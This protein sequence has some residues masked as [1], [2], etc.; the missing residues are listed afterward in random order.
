MKQP[1]RLFDF[2]YYQLQNQPLEKMMSSRLAGEWH[3]ISTQDFVEK[4]NLVSRGL[5]AMGIQ[6]GDAISLI[7]ENNRLE[8]NILDHGILQVGAVD[9][10]VYPTMTEQDYEYIMN[11]AEVKLCFVSSKEL[12]DKVNR[13]KDSIPSLQKIYTFEK[14][15]GLPH[16]TDIFSEAG[17]VEQQQ[18]DAISATV[19]SEDLASL[20]YTSGTTGLPKGVMLS[21]R[22]IVSNVLDSTP[23]LP[24]LKTGEARALSFLPCCHIFE[25]M[26]QYLYVYH[27]V[28]MYLT[29][30]D[31][32]KEDLMVAKPSMFTGVPRLFEKF[33]DGIRANG[34]S[35]EGFKKKVFIWAHDLACN[36]EPEGKNGWWYE[37]K[38]KIADKLV[39]SKIRTALGLTEI[40]AIACGSAALQPKLA[41][42]FT[43]C[44]IPI[45]EGYGLTETSPVISVNTLRHPKMWRWGTTGFPLDNIEVKIAPDGEIL[46]KGPNV[47]MGYYKAPELTAEVLKD[48]WFHTG[49]IGEIRDGFIIITDRKKEL[50]KTS[51]G[52][53]VAPQVVENAMKESVY[54]EQLIVIGDGEKFPAALI[55]PDFVMLKKWCESNGVDSSSPEAMIA[56]DKVEKLIHEEIERLN[57][58]F[59]NWEQVKAFRMLP[60]LFNIEEGEITP[61][62][63]LKRKKI[64][65]NWKAL[66]DDIYDRQ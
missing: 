16:W 59:G 53:Y 11:H 6:K 62:L 57:Q 52:K 46:C 28:S 12:Y 2:P 14:V 66:V 10:P 63:S 35:N 1:T 51:G 21:H 56:S 50:F 54:I 27:S 44:G 31:N 7:T 19:K 18:V 40:Q 20:I 9:V 64:T 41:R 49:D 45:L 3:S 42:F 36:W 37:F 17:K 5:M 58:R 61:K 32:V 34:L 47:M 25:R 24:K 33:Y 15:D 13:V 30:L 23:R 43:G 29:G 22:N 60:R 26:L 38:L 8:W 55:I 4:M 48:G 65:Q 39:F